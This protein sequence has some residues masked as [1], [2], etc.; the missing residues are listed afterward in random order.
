PYPQNNILKNISLLQ[1]SG[2]YFFKNGALERKSSLL[3]GGP[4]TSI[5]EALDR[6]AVQLDPIF[7]TGAPI[8]V[9]I[10]GGLDSRLNLALATFFS[11]KHGNLVRGFHEYKDED[12]YQ[13][14]RTVAEA[15]QIHLTVK[16]RT[17]FA[18]PSREMFLDADLI[19]LQSGPYRENLI[20][21]HR[22]LDWIRQEMPACIILGL[23][24]EAHKGK[25][26][27]QILSIEKDS[28]AVFGID[29]LI[30]EAIAQ[31]LGIKEYNKK[32]QK[33]FF[34][35]LIKDAARF[36]N[37]CGSID[38]IHYQTYIS[39][40][41]GKRCHDLMQYFAIPFPFLDN[42]FLRLVFALAQESKEGFKIVREG[43]RCFDTRLANIP[44]TSANEKSLKPRK[45]RRWDFLRSAA[46]NVLGGRYYTMMPT[47][48]KGRKKLSSTELDL[49]AK[50]EPASEITAL[51]K[52]RA[53][54]GIDD[55]PFVQWDYIAQML[56]YLSQCEQRRKITFCLK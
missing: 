31:K 55:V 35:T 4:K 33:Q 3:E 47:T 45:K 44:F 32:S 11:Q 14:A 28:E 51:L 50:I 42:E 5:S 2:N 37:L 25:Y 41:Y 10:S 24:A 52:A 26:Y 46:K 34:E 56:F 7:Q 29:P 9:L 17:N 21:W 12:E 18:E 49:I 15:V 22:Y 6:I 1:A 54:S 27:K 48:R 13:I 38:F 39:N 8:A 20:R 43:I 19:D 23:G 40:G 36:N 16:R 30:I 53:L